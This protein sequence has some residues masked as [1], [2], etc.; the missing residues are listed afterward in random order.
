MNGNL[1]IALAVKLQGAVMAKDQKG[2]AK[3]VLAGGTYN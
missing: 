3:P 1:M 2:S